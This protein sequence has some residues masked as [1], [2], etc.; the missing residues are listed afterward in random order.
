[1]RSCLEIKMTKE[2]LKLK[3]ISAI[4]LGCDK[5]KVDLQ[6]MLFWLKEYGFE[7]ISDLDEA[8]VIIVNTCAFITPAK[9]EAIENILLAISKKRNNCEKVIVTG[10]LPQRNLEQLQELFPEVDYF[11]Q[12]KDNE[13]IV[14]YLEKCYDV[15]QS[16]L[17]NNLGRVSTFGSGY[18]HL[19]IADG[20]N[21]GCSFCA[22]PRIRGRYRSVDIKK[23]VKEAE[24]LCNNNIQEII[25]VAQDVTR[26]GFDLYGENKLVE[27]IEQLSKIKKLKWIRLHYCY[28]ELIDDALLECI[29]KNPKVCKYLDIPLQHIDDK[30]LKHMNRRLDEKQ[31]RLFI[32]HLKRDYP[33]ITIRSTFIVGYPGETRKAFK[34]L[35]DFLKTSLLDNVGFFKYYREENTKAYFSKNQIREFIKNFRLKKVQN[36]QTKIA[37]DLNLKRIGEE[38][39]V[40]MDEYNQEANYYLGHD[41]KNSPEVDFSFIITTD[42]ELKI[43]QIYKVKISDYK[44]TYFIGEYLYESSK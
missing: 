6:H 43:G 19:K 41:M 14:N 38:V 11:I 40:M 21:N 36:I 37:D 22:I 28:P 5:N 13:K 20:C 27:L 23:L 8:N 31:T 10:C 24:N 34:K 7:I 26:Y 42:Q 2:E 25:L 33:Q 16:K 44:N 29:V 12:L 39:E 35:C 15:E 17:E 30:I 18:A 9:E 1:M 3:K 32:E 4:S